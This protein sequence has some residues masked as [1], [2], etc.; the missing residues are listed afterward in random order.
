MYS[1]QGYA[2]LYPATLSSPPPIVI[3]GHYAPNHKEEGASTTKRQGSWVCSR[4]WSETNNT[5]SYVHVQVLATFVHTALYPVNKMLHTTACKLS[6][7][8]V[9]DSTLTSLSPLVYRGRNARM[10]RRVPNTYQSLLL[11]APLFLCRKIMLS[12][13]LAKK[14]KNCTVKWQR[15]RRY[16]L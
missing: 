5:G 3:M 8:H 12:S 11:L 7:V 9:H 1:L 13:K 10:R 14:K 15:R 2:G 16:Y 4:P 6:L